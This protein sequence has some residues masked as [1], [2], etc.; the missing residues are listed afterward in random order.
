MSAAKTHTP[1]FDNPSAITCKVT[2]LPVPVAPATRPCRLASLRV[3]YSGLLL[4]P[5]NIVPSSGLLS[6]M[7][8]SSRIARGELRRQFIGHRL[9]RCHTAVRNGDVHAAGA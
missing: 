6:A 9:H 4:L 2:V 7:L 8:S 1:A 3:R 5:T